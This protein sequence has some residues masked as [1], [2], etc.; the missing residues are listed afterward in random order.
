MRNLHITVL[1]S[2]LSYSASSFDFEKNQGPLVTNMNS[3]EESEINATDLSIHSALEQKSEAKEVE[4]DLVLLYQ[5]QIDIDSTDGDAWLGLARVYYNRNQI[6]KAKEIISQGLLNQ[7]GS[8]DLQ[9]QLGIYQF[10]SK[11][12]S[13]ASQTL[14]TILL[15]EPGNDIAIKLLDKIIS[16][17]LRSVNF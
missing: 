5:Q 8:P 4:S 11:S 16:I 2:L 14:K 15:Y 12:Y 13:D 10:L 1:L 9:L 7:P 3:I 17:E 6:I